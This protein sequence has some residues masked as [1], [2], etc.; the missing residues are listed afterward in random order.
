MLKDLKKLIKFVLF[1]PFKKEAERYQ[2]TILKLQKSIESYNISVNNQQKKIKSLER[3]LTKYKRAS[4]INPLLNLNTTK[5]IKIY[6]KDKKSKFAELS[7]KFYTDKSSLL[8]SKK[9]PWESHSYEIIYENLFDKNE[10]LKIFELGIGTN[11]PNFKSNMTRH[12]K[13]GASLR[14]FSEFFKNADIYGGDIDHN[15]LFNTKRIKTFQVD[16]CNKKSIL[17]LWNNFNLDFFDLIIDDGLHE[18]SASKVFFTNSIKYL[19]KGGYYIIED[20]INK[21]INEYFKFYSTL[22]NFDFEVVAFINQKKNY[23]DTLIILRKLR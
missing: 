1:L 2:D 8:N 20:V 22:K 6:S 9:F 4:F 16:Q 15:I 5:F 10:K 19:K 21:D 14:V 17:R 3:D 13:P 12:G 7:D 23:D 11:N 18:F